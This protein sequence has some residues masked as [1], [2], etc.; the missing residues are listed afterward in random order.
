MA[1]KATNDFTLD[2]LLGKLTVGQ[3]SN[4]R[5]NL[6]LKNMSSLRKP[7]LIQALTDKIPGTVPEQLSYMTEQQY[8]VVEELLS[9]DGMTQTNSI[10]LIFLNSIGYTHPVE[11]DGEAF[12]VLPEE[13]M[14]QIRS[15]E[16]AELKRVLKKNQRIGNLLAV[17]LHGYGA[18]TLSDAHVMIEKE[19]GEAIDAKWFRNFICILSETYDLFHLNGDYIVDELVKDEA[20]LIEAQ[21]AMGD[22]PYAA[23]DAKEAAKVRGFD[24]IEYTPQLKEL[25]AY[26]LKTYGVPA[27]EL[28]ELLDETVYR[29]QLQESLSDVAAFFGNFI[30]FQDTKEIQVLID[31]LIKVMRATRM[32]SFKG[33]TT[34]EI[35]PP[36]EEKPAL[37]VLNTPQ[38][39]VQA[40]VTVN[41]SNKKVGRNDPCPCGSGKKFKKCCGK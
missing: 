16:E 33:H 13:I 22:L 31:K 30:D 8:T 3:L 27:E 32:W 15:M 4:I 35:A 19:I 6:E 37:K 40:S 1:V 25:K 28:E 26:L 2:Q 12:A 17:M 20:A 21:K 24:Y 14:T 39:A 41:D 10:E 7:E 34:D 38:A 29:I 18:I 9:N 11:V 5:K 23:I 36:A